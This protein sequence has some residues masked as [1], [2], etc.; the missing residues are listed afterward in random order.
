MT[1]RKMITIDLSADAGSVNIIPYPREAAERL[2]Y[3]RGFNAYMLYKHLPDE[4]KS[5]SPE[6][7]LIIT[8]GLLTGQRAPTV[9]RIHV[10]S[11]SPLTGILGSSNMGGNFGRCMQRSQIYSIMITGKADSPVYIHI[12]ENGVAV[13]DARTYWGLDT[14]ETRERILSDLSLK[15]HKAGI[16]AIGPAGENGVCFACIVS[17]K[18]H[19]AGRTGM[20]AVM[21]S[22]N[23]K[24]VI[25]TDGGKP[26]DTSGAESKENHNGEDAINNYVS[27]IKGSSE[28]KPFSTHGSAGYMNWANDKKLLGVKNYKD[29]QFPETDKLDAS[30]L[31]VVK[32]QG[33]PGCPIRCKAQVK[34]N[35]NGD[36]KRDN[37][38]VYY[39]PEFESTAALGPKC[40]L[41]DPEALTYLDNL[42][43]RMGIDTIS[44]GGVIAFAMD[45]YE[46]GILTMNDTG[47]I[48]F[49]WGNAI[50]ME[51]LIR[52]IS[53]VKGIGAVLAQGVRNAAKLIGKGAEYH[54]AHV[55]GLELA[56]YNP[57]ATMGTALGYA[58]SSRGGDFSSIYASL[59]HS[60]PKEKG[61]AVFGDGDVVDMTTIKGKGVLI[62]RAAIV[63]AVVDSIGICKVPALSLVSEFNLENEAALVS[64]ITGVDVGAKDLL[65]LGKNVIEFERCFNLKFGEKS[66]FMFGSDDFRD[67]LPDMFSENGRKNPAD[68]GRKAIPVKEMV[69]D[70]Y[71]EMG[72]DERGVPKSM[73]CIDTPE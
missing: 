33:C 51:S 73:K 26:K 60:W 50:A 11:L 57:A 24:A 16:M 25:V 21:G 30:H 22:K 7:I 49:T 64:A 34:F 58:I 52:D 69:K 10:S 42:C 37:A 18:D 13:K 28:F 40:G 62:K 38:G 6:N 48:P 31:S 41:S 2:L 20:G 72:W 59:E 15:D 8:A 44:T 3:G 70:F 17:E 36:H 71:K 12:D 65:T 14:W 54:A 53:A 56:A 1:T 5:Q 67:D 32:H 39:R 27:K 61:E 23:L 19:A 4:A 47:G 29:E 35:G 43:T 46:N 63:N 66:G 68:A 45:L 55:K 9:S